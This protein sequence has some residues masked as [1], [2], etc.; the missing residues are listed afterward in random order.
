MIATPIAEHGITMSNGTA[1]NDSRRLQAIY[2]VH[3]VLNQMESSKLDIQTLLGRIIDVAVSQIGANE[4]TL[5]IVNQDLEV[6]YAWLVNQEAAPSLLNKIIDDGLAGQVIRSQKPIIIKD[7]CADPRWLTNKDDVTSHEPWSVICVPVVNHGYTTG[8]VTLH[9]AGIG[10]FAPT[11]IDLLTTIT[12]QVA[13]F[14]ENARLYEQSQR[15]L[16]ASALLQEASHIINST[17]KIDEVMQALLNQMNNLL[18]A[19]A[20]S[21]ALV[22][23][24]ANELVY[25]VAE[26]PGSEKIEG[27]RMP[28][29]QGLSGWVMNNKE[30]I[31]VSDA[32]ADPRFNPEGDRRTGYQTRAM[33]CAPMIFKGQVL[34]TIQAVNPSKG[35]FTQRDLTL[36]VNLANIAS[37][38]LANAQQ[39]AQTVAAEKRYM[40]L[41]QDSIEPILL[42]DVQGQ[43]VEAN[44]QAIAF[45]GYSREELIDHIIDM[46]HSE[47]NG[48]PKML[49]IAD[50][51]VKQFT[52][53][54]LTKKGIMIPVEVYAKR[55]QFGRQ[56]LL[57]WIYRD[58][59]E[60]VE[61]EQM[62]E[63]LIA[64]LFHDL[65]SPL[66][67]VISS[68]ALMKDELPQES[69]PALHLMLDIA[70]RSSS[71]LQTL[72][73]S[74]LDITRLE[75][76]H[77]VSDRREVDLNQ[78]VQDVW[79]YEEP[80]FDR[81]SVSFHREIDHDLPLVYVEEDMI[82][83]VLVN[84][85]SN[86]LKYSIEGD[87]IIVSARHG[88]ENDDA[89]ILVSVV[90]QGQGVPPQHRM[91]IFD[92]FQRIASAKASSSGLG[93]GLAFCR[94][95]VEA[96]G[97][98]I[99][100]DDA[101][102]GGARFNLTLPVAYEMPAYTE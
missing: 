58:I 41:F 93:L 12:N 57:Q 25:R 48:L 54:V 55:T 89:K 94:L 99:W 65:Q 4:G 39:Y 16:K 29:N 73:R 82:R 75:A 67:N 61:L 14:I 96:H 7:T 33:M 56:E 77:P 60:Q 13:S 49:A 90:D 31:L 79:E 30:A 26:G 10:Q 44:R 102:G 69:D 20:I 19:E 100:V 35:P 76:G 98:K 70:S 17:L 84:L 91:S 1:I 92:K 18:N 9:K 8:V 66:G 45:F 15:Q 51:E 64:M 85:I 21:I 43:I 36:L 42:S 86:A 71:R 62:R 101:P 24:Q 83:R 47:D 6:E 63:D 23:Q 46:L 38:A 78:L 74:L 37:S 11:D 87:F 2:A 22:D 59:S 40:N 28:S 32:A 52:G 88:W 5:L 95:A 68:L 34:G 81:R 50:N 72:V 80:N 53:Q 3:T 97:G 27:L